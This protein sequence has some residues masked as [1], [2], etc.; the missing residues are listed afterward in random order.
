MHRNYHSQFADDLQ[1]LVHRWWSHKKKNFEIKIFREYS[2][3][4]HDLSMFHEYY[5][6]LPYTLFGQRQKIYPFISVE[7]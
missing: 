2:N 3:K 4:R 6:N 1:I 5:E 7:Y